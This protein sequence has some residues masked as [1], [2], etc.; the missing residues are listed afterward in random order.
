MELQSYMQLQGF[1]FFFIGR[2]AVQRWG[3]PRVTII[4]QGMS[5]NRGIIREELETLA[6]L[7]EEPE[8]L[9]QLESLF[10]KHN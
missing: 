5:L 9:T 8:I 4:R 1:R 7:K 2:V 10:Q 6:S 3:E